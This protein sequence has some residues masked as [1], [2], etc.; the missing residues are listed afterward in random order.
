MIGG[1]LDQTYNG[2]LFPV[3][4][5]CMVLETVYLSTT[6]R[7]IKLESPLESKLC[8]NRSNW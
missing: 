7:I 1:Q 8:T 4:S 2:P 5:D 6:E 3:A